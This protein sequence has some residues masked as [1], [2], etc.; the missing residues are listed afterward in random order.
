MVLAVKV[1]VLKRTQMVPQPLDQAFK[2]FTDPLS[3]EILMPSAMGFR[4]VG[5]KPDAIEAG[6]IFNY[7]FFLFRIPIYWQT[8]VESVDPPHSLIGVQQKGPLAHW[9]HTQTFIAAGAKTT[10]V[11]DRFEFGLPLGRIGEFAYR[12]WGKAKIRQLLEYRANKMDLLMH[13]NPQRPARAEATPQAPR[14]PQA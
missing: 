2:F 5:E 6:T 11:R 10:E 7:R 14:Q 4:L 1:R 12:S 13:V 9:R 8:K 3:L